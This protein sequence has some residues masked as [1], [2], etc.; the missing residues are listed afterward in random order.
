MLRMLRG[1]EY[2]RGDSPI[3]RLDPRVK[4]VYSLSLIHI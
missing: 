4:I 1:F 3:H 2:L